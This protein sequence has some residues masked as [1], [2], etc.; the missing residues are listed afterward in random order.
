VISYYKLLSKVM[1]RNSDSWRMQE[2]WTMD[3]TPLLP[4]MSMY[5]PGRLLISF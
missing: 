2:N 3:N 5:P 1:R 4:W